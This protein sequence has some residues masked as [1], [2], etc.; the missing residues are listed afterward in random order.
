MLPPRHFEPPLENQDSGISSRENEPVPERPRK[1][2]SWPMLG[3]LKKVTEVSRWMNDAWGKFLGFQDKWKWLDGKLVREGWV[4]E[5]EVQTPV[6]PSVKESDIEINGADW[7][8]NV[9]SQPDYTP[10][11]P[12]PPTI[13]CVSCLLPGHQ[14]GRQECRFPQMRCQNCGHEHTQTLICKEVEHTLT[15]GGNPLNL[16]PKQRTKDTPV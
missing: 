14:G 8:H 16:A 9:D 2:V 1:N 7:I 15:Y 12:P 3:E 5:T 13:F 10:S 6:T 11:A 4:N